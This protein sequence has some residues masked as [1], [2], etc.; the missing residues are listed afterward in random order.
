MERFNCET[1][2]KVFNIEGLDSI[3]IES[4]AE[5]D[6]IKIPSCRTMKLNRIANF[7]DK[8]LEI[9]QIRSGNDDVIYQKEK[10]NYIRDM[11]NWI[12][13]NIEDM[14]YQQS[15]LLT[16]LNRKRKN[17]TDTERLTPSEYKKIRERF[18][19][20]IEM[21][22]E[23]LIKSLYKKKPESTIKY[24]QINKSNLIARQQK[25]EDAIHQQRNFLKKNKDVLCRN[26]YSEL[27]F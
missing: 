11:N 1:L 18:L 5:I 2:N 9:L 10:D 4:V 25:L 12:T 22:D 14:Q 15:A 20:F 13:K 17:I 16:H 26:K 7:V 23:D 21:L 27:A 19:V 6:S 24:N 8:K 3:L